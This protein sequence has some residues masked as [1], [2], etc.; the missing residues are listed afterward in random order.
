[1]MCRFVITEA[2]TQPRSLQAF[3]ADGYRFDAAASSENEWVFKR[4]Q[5]AG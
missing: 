1:M 4:P 5:Q 3:N 2:L